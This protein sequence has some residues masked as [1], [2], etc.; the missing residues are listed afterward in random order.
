MELYK[1]EENYYKK[2][3]EVDEKVPSLEN[4]KGARPFLGFILKVNYKNYFAPLTSPKR[5]HETMKDKIDFIKI[6]DGKLGAINL[7]NMIPIPISRCKVIS[8]E[9][10]TDKKY[11]ELLTK[12]LQWCKENEFQIIARAHKLYDTICYQKEN[13]EL[14]QRCCDFKALEEKCFTYMKENQIRE[15]ELFAYIY[16]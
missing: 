8:I 2:L 13:K 16:E 14:K 6:K 4:E 9:E 15:E 7:N 12:Q 10:I 5:K 11:R 3:K 1:I